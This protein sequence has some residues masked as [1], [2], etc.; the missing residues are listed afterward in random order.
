MAFL[1]TFLRK[2]PHGQKKGQHFLHVVL[3]IVR[4]LAAL[5][6]NRQHILVHV[7][8]PAVLGIQLVTEQQPKCAGWRMVG[9]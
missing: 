2:V 6:H 9:T 3:R 5:H 1:L 7:F 8:P 4:L